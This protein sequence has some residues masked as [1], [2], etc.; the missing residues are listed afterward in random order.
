MQCMSLC[1]CMYL[2]VC[3]YVPAFVF[4]RVCVSVCVTVDGVYVW[5]M[6][7]SAFVCVCF[8]SVY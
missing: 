5:C 6:S 4:V 3:L 1:V 8:V 2:L 7:V